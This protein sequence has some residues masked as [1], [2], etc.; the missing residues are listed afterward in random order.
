MNI[1]Y[2]NDISKAKVLVFG[3][4][5]VD[6]YVIGDVNR[7]SPEAP[8][9][10]IEITKQSRKLGGAGNVI[11]NIRSL[12][13]NVRVLGAVGKDNAGDYIYQEFLDKKVDVKY[14]KQYSECNTIIKTRVVSRKQQFFRIDA[15]D[16]KEL[17]QKYIDFVNNKINSILSGITSVVISDYAKG[18]VNENIA[19]LIITNANKLNIPVIIDP[20]GKDYSKY[21]G[22][23]LCTPNLKEL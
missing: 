11:N 3:D 10:V 19:Q 6:E 9:P 21:K 1:D 14:F 16:K 4:Y 22:A 8:V 15:E 20:K 2:L 17:P 7:I 18:A 13:A 12:G 23:T 5:M